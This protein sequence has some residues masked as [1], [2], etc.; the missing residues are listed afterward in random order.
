MS[1]AAINDEEDPDYKDIE[2]D[3]AFNLTDEELRAICLCIQEVALPTWVARPF[4]NLG[5]ARHGK[6]KADVYL[7]LFTVILPHVLPGLWWNKASI[8]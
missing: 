8:Y 1:H 6:L 3:N 7:V 2:S 4:T 5:E